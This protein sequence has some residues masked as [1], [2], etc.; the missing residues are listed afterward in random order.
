MTRRAI[1]MRLFVALAL[2]LAIGLAFFL[3]PHASSSPDGLNRVAGDKGF[4][5]SA[6]VHAIQEDSP[7]PGYAFPGIDDEKLAQGVAGFVGTLGV[8][9]LGYGAAVTIR[10]TRA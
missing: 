8:F 4:D 3:S 9:A 1:S 10:R 5:A 2:S 7:I 6:R